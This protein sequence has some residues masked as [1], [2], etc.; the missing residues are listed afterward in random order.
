MR[1]K[2]KIFPPKRKI[3]E[4]KGEKYKIIA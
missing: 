1:Y 2:N 3:M 4:I